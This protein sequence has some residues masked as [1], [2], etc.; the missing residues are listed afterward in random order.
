MK[1]YNLEV[2][3][4]DVRTVTTGLCNSPDIRSFKVQWNRD[5]KKAIVPTATV[6]IEVTY[7]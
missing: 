1:V 4:E 7:N 5:L 2:R 3:F 6:N